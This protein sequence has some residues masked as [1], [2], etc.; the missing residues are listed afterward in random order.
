M[1]VL[2][3]D[4]FEKSGLDGLA[5]AGCEVVIDPS[6]K[7]DALVEALRESRADVLIVRSTKVSAAMM[8]AG[9]TRA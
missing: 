8:D 1:K 7:D 4:P 9:A 5:A 6:L 2:I 3:A